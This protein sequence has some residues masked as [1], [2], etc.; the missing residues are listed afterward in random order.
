[1]RNGLKPNA[2]STDCRNSVEDTW[3]W[4]ICA[5]STSFSSSRRKVSINV[6]LPQPIS[7]V[8]TTKPSVNQTVDSM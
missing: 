2:T 7:P 5:T 6:V 8:M 4:L 1:M 3:V